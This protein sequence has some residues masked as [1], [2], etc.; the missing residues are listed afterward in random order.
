MGLAQPRPH[1]LAIDTHAHIFV[2]GL[3]LA[4]VRRY[5]PDYDAT[6]ADYLALLDAHGLSHGVLVQTSFLG[7]DNSFML[8]A[9][10]QARGRLRGVAV[11]DTDT[12]PAELSDMN[13]AGVRGIRLNL[14]GRETPA[15]DSAPWQTLLEA[16]NA[17]GW[18][19]EVYMPASRL[20]E[21]VT[22]LLAAGC[23][24]VVDHFGRPDPALGIADPGF[25]YLLDQADTQRV[26]VKLSAPYRIWQPA[27]CA[28][29]GR[30]ATHKLLT[31]F[32]AERLLWGS[33]WPHTENR[34][35]A[36]YRLA[37]DWLRAWIDD[38]ATR[39]IIL[40]DTP[41]ALFGITGDHP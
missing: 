29:L 31:A 30:Q 36:D 8:A 27:D 19:V 32:P 22:P 33:D 12:T 10:A 17:L 16:I 28:P 13:L 6:L 14:M 40:A 37:C 25:T 18:H 34:D 23:R 35:R 2:R 4:G 7:T 9:L 26:W 11:I 5:T 3:P 41:S 24:V 1:T 38:D 39:H 20:P 21:A 15:L